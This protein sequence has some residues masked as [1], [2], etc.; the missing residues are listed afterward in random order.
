MTAIGTMTTQ[1]HP[2][3]A[4]PVRELMRRPI[5]GCEE[6][7][8]LRQVARMMGFHRVHCVVVFR[9]APEGD[10][11]PRRVE[12]LLGVA[13]PLRRL[14]GAEHRSAGDVAATPLITVRPN[15]TLGRAAQLMEEYAA[16]HVL[17]TA[18]NGQPLGIV[19]TLELARA[20]GHR[21][22]V[23]PAPEDGA[24]GEGGEGP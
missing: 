4:R 17:V 2:A 23:F 13:E 1:V 7:V 18:T 24:A 19:S 3:L 16:A 5:V 8:P 15:E 14:A 6:D 11:R 20:V 22:I 10:H 12:H 9:D 21:D